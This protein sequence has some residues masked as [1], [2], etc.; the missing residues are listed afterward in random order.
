LNLDEIQKLIEILEGTD[1]TEIGIEEE[2]FSIKL[3]KGSSAEKSSIPAQM[4]QPATVPQAV[5]N[6]GVSISDTEEITQEKKK[7]ENIK[8]VEAP[9]VGTFYR[10]PAPDAEPFVEVGDIVR[11]NETLC[12]IEAMKLMNE[13][14][15]EIKGRIVDILVED[16]EAVEYGQTLFIIEQV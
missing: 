12:I 14:E 16:G 8:E 2:D 10:A 1:I 3:K 7:N 15:A 9:M 4:K 5:P 11:E 13:I 6:S